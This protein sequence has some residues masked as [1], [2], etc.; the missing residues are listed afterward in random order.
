MVD[1]AIS[2]NLTVLVLLEIYVNAETLFE[3]EDKLLKLILLLFTQRFT[4]F[5][6]DFL[7]IWIGFW[8]SRLFLLGL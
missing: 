1:S 4:V 2:T 3:C 6:K 8:T 7:Y 5:V